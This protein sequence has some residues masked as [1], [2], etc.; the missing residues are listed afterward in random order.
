MRLKSATKY[1]ACS[2]TSSDDE[3]KY[4]AHEIKYQDNEMTYQEE[5]VEQAL[6][7]CGKAA[8]QQ[9]LQPLR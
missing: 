5:R 9:R 4:Q 8:E 6:Q 2:R 7:A 1:F 3:V